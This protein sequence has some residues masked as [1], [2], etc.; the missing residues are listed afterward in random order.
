MSPETLEYGRSHCP[1]EGAR[2]VLLFGGCVGHF[3]EEMVK[4]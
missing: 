1:R 2:G 4:S 3:E